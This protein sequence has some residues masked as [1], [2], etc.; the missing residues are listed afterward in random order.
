MIRR[1]LV[2]GLML[3]LATPAMADDP[4]DMVASAQRLADAA[5]GALARRSL[6]QVALPTVATAKFRAVR[7][8]YI[9]WELVNDQIVFCGELDA[10][11]P[12]SGK[13][14]GWTR[15]AYLPGDP[16]T[17]ATETEGL[18]IHELGKRIVAK[19]CDAP[20]A[21]W[22]SADYTRQF[23]TLPKDLAEAAS[24]AGGQQ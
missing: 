21:K 2:G 10:V 18:G 16:T 13:R 6:G 7:A 12:A 5:V 20:D 9:R 8:Q 24:A 17:L 14:S 22:M 3:S 1:L 4:P 23:Q 15:F 11:I 19:Y